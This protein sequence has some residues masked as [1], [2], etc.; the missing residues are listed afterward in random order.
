[1]NQKQECL[2][3]QDQLIHVIEKVCEIKWVE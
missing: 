2:D 3:F 1:V